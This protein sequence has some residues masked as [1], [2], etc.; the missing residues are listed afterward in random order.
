M[1]VPC[2][3]SSN[4][5]W[6]WAFLIFSTFFMADH[7][8]NFQSCTAVVGEVRRVYAYYERGTFGY[9]HVAL[10]FL[11]IKPH[12]GLLPE[13]IQYSMT[14]EGS[15]YIKF[16]YSE[17]IRVRGGCHCFIILYQFEVGSCGRRVAVVWRA[18]G[19]VCWKREFTLSLTPVWL[20]VA[21][22]PVPLPS[23]S[24]YRL[25]CEAASSIPSFASSTHSPKP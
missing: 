8:L 16:V 11:W 24:Q 4:L 19:V 25:V 2:S 13:W 5:S 9:N 21:E 17:G 7:E 23:S 6:I 22:R 10:H 15:A 3:F 14:Q 18:A 1:E 12:F 20:G